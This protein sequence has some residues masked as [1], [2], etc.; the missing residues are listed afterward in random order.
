VVARIRWGIVRVIE[1][2][3]GLDTA[4]VPWEVQVEELP[5]IVF[6]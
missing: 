5:R 6:G 3:I 1:H 2:P 4:C